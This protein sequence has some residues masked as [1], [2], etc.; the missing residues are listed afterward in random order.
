VANRGEVALRIMAAAADLGLQTIAVFSADDEGAAHARRA[1]VA[2]PLRDQGP[3]A[4]LDVDA[5]VQIARQH[6]ATLVH[7]GYGFL[8]ESAA[9]SRACAAIGVTFVGPTPEVLETFGDKARAR[10][11]AGACGVPTVPGSSGPVTRAEA[12]EFLD[13]LPVGTAMMIKA[14]AGGG[15]RGIRIVADRHDVQLAFDHCQAEARAAFG[16]GAVYVEQ[17]VERPRHIEVQLVGDGSSVI[18]LGDRDCT[19]QRRNQKIVE[20]CPSPWLDA[21]LREAMHEAAMRMAA[22]VGYAGL[23]TVEFLVAPALPSGF[24]FMEVNARLQVEHTV[25][26]QVYGIDLVGAQIR[27]AAGETLEELGLH[28]PGRP[29]ARGFALQ[30]RVN[31]EV[32]APDGSTRP[33]QGLLTRFDVPTGAGIR[34]DTAASA[35]SAVSSRYDPLLAKLVVHIPDGA[36]D[37]TL[38]AA[39]RAL[40]EFG[41]EGVGTNLPVLRA[42]LGDPRVA[43]GEIDTRFVE[44]NIAQLTPADPPS[45]SSPV[46]E[47]GVVRTGL[48]GV[49]ISVVEPGSRVHAGQEIA[50]VEAMKMEHPIVAPRDGGIVE[51]LVEIG[52]VV[53]E[54]D[55]VLLIE[56][57]HA[58]MAESAQDG[59]VEDPGVLHALEEVRARHEALLDAA[60]P[61]AVARRHAHDQLT[62]REKIDLLC[63]PG[64]FVEYGG[65]I[66]AGQRRRHDLETLRVRS[67]ADGVVVGIGEIAEETDPTRTRQCA[68]VGYDYTV[69]AGTQGHQGYRKVTRMLTVAEQLKLP[70]ILFAEGGGGRAGETDGLNAFGLDTPTFRTMARLSGLVPMIGLVSGRCFAGN[71]ALLG[72]CDVVMATRAS[73]LGMGGPAMIEGAGLGTVD[74]DDIG[75]A[76]DQAERGVVDVL[77][78]DDAELLRA[79]RRYFG[80]FAFDGWREDAPHHDQEALRY[81]IPSNRRR[82]YD[83]RRIIELLCDVESTLELRSSFGRAIVAALGRIGGRVVGIV[84]NDPGHLAGAIDSHG[85]DKAARFISMCDAHD[86]PIVAL[87]D[88]P[89]IAVGPAA[90]R[91]A[92]VRHSSR[93]F[94]ATANATTPIY[95]VVVRRAFGLGAQAMVAGSVHAPVM[96]VAWPGAQFG[97]MGVEGMVTLGYRN[98]MAAIEDP[99]ER[100]AYFD[101]K[102]AETYE[103]GSA[104]VAATHFELDDVIDHAETRHWLLTGLRSVAPRTVRAEKKRTYIDAW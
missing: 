41:V 62:V 36:F 85:A 46:D 68:I 12:Y 15:G 55:V 95:A 49:V 70:V 83:I 5:I 75:P 60:R 24:A 84:A 43:S 91:E 1:D 8:G 17:L 103:R 25:T 57:S 69:L 101:E 45:T 52:Q 77:V 72:C 50:V 53:T 23:G 48:A 16:D 93:L 29:G 96:T 35:G 80:F 88:T 54:G 14:V 66:V 31:S 79:A 74:P 2:V 47:D 64:T 11:L 73:S 90:E 34:I 33:S 7:P 65:L 37:R 86:I 87:C 56:E 71:A 42:L 98:E 10:A 76:P 22:Q 3:R 104:L 38:R 9:L 39:A 102:V 27:L 28:E 81:V 40:D 58:G 32:I 4:Y 59:P 19:L 30:A 44:R 20:L 21:S 18:A 63:V 82:S 92:T 61:E 13:R 78:D 26:E 6:D 89:G 94:L 100:A 67:P 51:V 97:S 99:V